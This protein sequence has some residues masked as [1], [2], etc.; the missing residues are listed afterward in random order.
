MGRVCVNSDEGM[1][2][3][4]SVTKVATDKDKHV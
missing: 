1:T 4:G 3:F 2:A